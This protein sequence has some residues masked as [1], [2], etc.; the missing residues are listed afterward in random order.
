ICSDLGQTSDVGACLCWVSAAR[1]TQKCQCSCREWFKDVRYPYL[2]V[3]SVWFIHKL[4]FDTHRSSQDSP[5]GFL[6]SPQVIPRS[7]PRKLVY[8]AERSRTCTARTVATPTP[9]GSTRGRLTMAQAFGGAANAHP[10][11]DGSPPSSRC[12]LLSSSE[13]VSSSRSIG[14]RSST[15]F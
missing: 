13:V 5:Q 3:T 12:S 1:R 10:A 11:S 15:G 14:T 8:R 9:R 7:V 4:W 2:V 6:R